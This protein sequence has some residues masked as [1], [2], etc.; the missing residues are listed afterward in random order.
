MLNKNLEFR[1]VNNYDPANSNDDLV[2]LLNGKFYNIEIV[3]PLKED[4]QSGVEKLDEILEQSFKNAEVT[5]HSPIKFVPSILFDWNNLAAELYPIFLV[6]S[7]SINK[8]FMMADQN[9][10]LPPKSTWLEPK[11][12]L[13][14]VIRMPN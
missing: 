1:E 10:I 3:A 5:T 11:P 9:K 12:C 4:S 13:H 14:M 2:L 6:K 7:P 8:I